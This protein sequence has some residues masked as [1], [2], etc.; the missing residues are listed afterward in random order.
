MAQPCQRSG[1][2]ETSLNVEL[3]FTPKAE[4]VARK[5]SLTKCRGRIEDHVRV[6]PVL[7]VLQVLM[8]FAN[9]NPDR[10]VWARGQWIHE[11]VLI[12]NR[13]M[14]RTTAFRALRWLKAHGWIKPVRMRPGKGKAEQRGVVVLTHEEYGANR[15]D[16]CH[17]VE[18]QTSQGSQPTNPEADLGQSQVGTE[19]FQSGTAKYQLGTAAVPKVADNACSSSGFQVHYS[20]PEV[21][22]EVS[23]EERKD[24]DGDALT[25]TRCA[26]HS[27]DAFL[28][29]GISRKRL[30]A[31]FRADEF[32]A[33]F[34]NIM[35][36]Y[37]GAVHTEGTCDCDPIEFLELAIVRHQT[38][39]I[40]Y[41][42]ALIAQKRELE[43]RRG[44]IEY[45]RTFSS[46][47]VAEDDRCF[48]GLRMSMTLAEFKKLPDE[49]LQKH[50]EILELRLGLAI[51]KSVLSCEK[52]GSLKLGFLAALSWAIDKI[53][54]A[55]EIECDSAK[56]FREVVRDRGAATDALE[57]FAGDFWSSYFTT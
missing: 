15:P 48:T 43:R 17:N 12:E 24:S 14:S 39:E 56:Q 32:A 37:R 53:F 21:L 26:F 9:K 13:P 51:H 44:E 11:N 34:E 1:H 57:Y 36:E 33:E 30:P 42:K 31:K 8:W 6:G 4:R 49:I 3:H 19:K 23:K 47:D 41:P 20:T 28:F 54:N 29:S 5:K 40:E 52:T 7:K 16:C 10:F 50:A 35:D 2:K 22:N 46:H 25:L 27:S 45:A 18:G 55:R 38:D